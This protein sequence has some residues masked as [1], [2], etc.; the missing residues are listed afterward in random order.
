VNKVP[1]LLVIMGPMGELVENAEL[2][3]RWQLRGSMGLLWTPSPKGGLP[4]NMVSRC[5]LRVVWRE[6]MRKLA[7]LP[8]WERACQR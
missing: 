7:T 5:L 8:C 2:G 4:S 3:A 1:G 6:W